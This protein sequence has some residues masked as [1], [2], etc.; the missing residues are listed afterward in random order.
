ML[1]IIKRIYNVKVGSFIMTWITNNNRSHI[2]ISY[3]TQW[4]DQVDCHPQQKAQKE[5]KKIETRL[6]SASTNDE[7]ISICLVV[8]LRRSSIKLNSLVI[9]DSICHSAAT[10]YH[11]CQQIAFAAKQ[12]CII[13]INIMNNLL[14]KATE[15]KKGRKKLFSFKKSSFD[16]SAHWCCWSDATS[17][18]HPFS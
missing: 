13:I 15:K 18:V 1:K 8:N 5:Y 6:L 3:P 17:S 9:L 14:A 16:G 10:N 12:K 4:L 2:N 11:W 7:F